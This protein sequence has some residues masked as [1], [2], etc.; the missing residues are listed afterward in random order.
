MKIAV[1]EHQKKFII[2]ESI[3][4]EFNSI[5]ERGYNFTKE[6]LEKSAEQIG[7]NIQFAI[8]W[9]ASIGGMVGPLNDFIKNTES[10][11]SDIEISLLLTGIIA[12]YYVD[13]KEY[14]KKILT[15]IKEEGLSE[16]FLR[17]F[18]KSQELKNA[19]FDFI[20]SLNIT[21]HKVTNIMSYTFI[22]PIIPMLYDMATSSNLD[23]EQI[24]E[25]AKRLSSFGV[26][27]VSGILVKELINKI[28]KRFKS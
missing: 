10:E 14:V 5:I 6:I 21:L 8:T 22:I 27:T 13:N 25:I 15:K 17:V 7:I 26:L 4:E 16:V 28:I 3:S 20:E 23:G 18:K 11:M 9:G 24:S 19:F 2:T 12:S 1:T